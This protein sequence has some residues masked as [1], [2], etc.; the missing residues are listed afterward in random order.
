MPRPKVRLTGVPE[1]GLWNLYHRAAAAQAGRLHDPH[2]IE[3]VSQL[4]YPF[5]QFDSPYRGLAARMHAQRVRT[6]DAALRQLLADAPG[7]TVVALGE[8]FETQF[9]RV[10]DGQLNWLTLDL[11]EVIEVRQAALPDDPRCRTTV[12]S[13]ADPDW[14]TQVDRERPVIITAQ[15]L[16]MYFERDDIHEMLGTWAQQLSPSWL[17]FD[18]V[19]ETLQASRR[20][21]PGSGPYHP[22]EWT[23]VL[24]DEEVRQLRQLPGVS[25]LS[26][27]AQDGDDRQLSL[28]RKV[29]GLKGLLPAFPV[30][31]AMLGQGS[32]SASPESG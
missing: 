25:E 21:S 18:G 26:A 32:V 1:T 27:V 20:R 6:I 2:A 14:I 16:L 4:D 12:G 17:L 23:W 5:E 8:G 11:P 13:A 9:W 24:T 22:P 31:R 19:T 3:L 28:A 10:D 15:G 30:F 29:P 7:A